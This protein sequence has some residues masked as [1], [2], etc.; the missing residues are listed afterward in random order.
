MTIKEVEEKLELPRATVRFYEREGLLN[1]K[2]SGNSYREYTEEDVAALKKIIVLRKIGLS[3]SDIESVFK[4]DVSLQDLLEKNISELQDK[5]KELE[6]AIRVCKEMQNKDEEASTLDQEYYWE[7][8]H[9]Q[10]QAGNKFLE[11]VNDVAQFERNVFLKEFELVNEEGQLI[12]G[13]KE[14]VFRALG[15]CV[16]AGFVCFFMDG[17]SWASFI[18]GF[19]WPFWCILVYSIFG[20]PLHFLGKKHPKVAKIIKNVGIGIV[21]VIFAVLLLIVTFGEEV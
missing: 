8:I 4:G 5:M 11:I 3:V 7:E 10:E 19:F 6:G 1:P 15:V 16:I 17:M 9:I 20:L 12:Y 21:L 2:R 14:S 18:E 13:K